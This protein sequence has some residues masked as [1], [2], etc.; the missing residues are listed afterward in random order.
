MTHQWSLSSVRYIYFCSMAEE[1]SS[2]LSASMVIGAGQPTLIPTPP[3]SGS[4]TM[5]P[6][7][8]VSVS[9]SLIV[10][11]GGQVSAHTFTAVR[12]VNPQPGDLPMEVEQSLH[13]EHFP[14]VT[15]HQPAT[16]D[17]E[18]P[19]HFTL[20]PQ[21]SRCQTAT[22]AHFHGNFGSFTIV[23]AATNQMLSPTTDQVAQMAP[24]RRINDSLLIGQTP[25]VPSVN[26]IGVF[27]K[28]DGVEE[29]PDVQNENGRRDS[30]Y[31]NG[32]ASSPLVPISESDLRYQAPA[33][34]GTPISEHAL[35][36]DHM[37]YPHECTEVSMECADNATCAVFADTC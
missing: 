16:P 8:P 29:T 21:A 25:D 1:T 19:Q 28:G 18:I 10:G 24:V 7:P 6:D 4:V 33:D 34:E 11:T 14:M 9:T 22:S 37:P 30:Q 27:V 17:G 20:I 31:Q 13:Q 32:D 3:A 26:S 5:I 2:H 23:G 15:S 12:G 36:D 35:Q